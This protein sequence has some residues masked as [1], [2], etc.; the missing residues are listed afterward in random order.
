M[1][2]GREGDEIEEEVAMVDK[3]CGAVTWVGAWT[4]VAGMISG[5]SWSG[6]GTAVDRPPVS[7]VVNI[8]FDSWGWVDIV[9]S[10]INDFSW[11][12]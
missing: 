5:G 9:A 6:F 3:A 12:L 8:W 4:G 1:E 7:T 10:G 11:C 2:G